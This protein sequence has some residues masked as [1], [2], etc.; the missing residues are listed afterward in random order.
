MQDGSLKLS[1]LESLLAIPIPKYTKQK[2]LSNLYS[3]NDE[4]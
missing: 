2:N 3:Y 1:K 4:N